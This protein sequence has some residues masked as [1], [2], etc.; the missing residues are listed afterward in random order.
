MLGISVKRSQPRGADGKYSNADGSAADKTITR[1]T[2][3]INTVNENALANL[4][5]T[6]KMADMFQ[7]QAISGMELMQNLE[8]AGD[9]GSDDSFMG[10]IKQAMPILKELLQGNNGH[11]LPVPPVVPPV[12]P[13]NPQPRPDLNEVLSTINKLPQ[14]IITEDGIKKFLPEGIEFKDFKQ[15]IK[16][17]HRGLD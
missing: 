15:A 11:A 10:I 5:N 9:S 2:K 8:P 3:I 12:P 17:I 4:Q 13:V 1:L 16:K 7:K 14:K 6:Q